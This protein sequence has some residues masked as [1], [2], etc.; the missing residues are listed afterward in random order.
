MTKLNPALFIS[1]TPI[2][3]QVTMPDGSVETLHFRQLS[4]QDLAKLQEERKSPNADLRTQA[5]QR[6]IARCL[7]DESGGTVLTFEQ[8]RNLTA[9][10]VAA[11]LP[12]VLEVNRAPGKANTPAAESTGSAAS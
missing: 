6:L 2:P 10:G 4:A 5:Q 3:Q 11:L 12:A 9:A 8:A 1:A 7:C